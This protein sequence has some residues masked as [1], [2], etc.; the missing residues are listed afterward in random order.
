MGGHFRWPRRRRGSA[1]EVRSTAEAVH[2]M[3]APHVHALPAADAARHPVTE[4]RAT[5]RRPSSWTSRRLAQ[6]HTRTCPDP[7]ATLG[8]GSRITLPTSFAA[9]FNGTVDGADANTFVVHGMQTGR[10]FLGEAH[11]GNGTGTVTSPESSTNA[12]FGGRRDRGVVDT[13]P[14]EPAC[15]TWRGCLR[16]ERRQRLRHTRRL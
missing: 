5:P 2:P 15:R 11:G 13:R 9:S 10:H 12:F 16:G 4:V 1:A 7:H 8:S 6:V 14:S 3:R